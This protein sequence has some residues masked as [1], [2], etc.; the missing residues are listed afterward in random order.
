MAPQRSTPKCH[1]FLKTFPGQR[2]KQTPSVK[3]LQ[4]VETK[5]A[6]PTNNT[7]ES[8]IG[9]LATATGYLFLAHAI[10]LSWDES[11]MKQKLRI[12]GLMRKNISRDKEQY[13]YLFFLY[14]H[15]SFHNK[16]WQ[17]TI[18]LLLLH[19]PG[20]CGTVRPASGVAWARASQ[21]LKP[22]LWPLVVTVCDRPYVR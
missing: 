3:G 5:R 7:G 6:S 15:T 21:C 17:W 13:P 16:P 12:Q 19:L 11:C 18:T 9:N 8:F 14:L 4:K 20:A 10:Y 2:T 22:T 1:R